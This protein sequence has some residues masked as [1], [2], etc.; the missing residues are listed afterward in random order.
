M[1]DLIY[2]V[3][4]GQTNKLMRDMGDGTHAD[5][6]AVGPGESHIG[7]IGGN[8]ALFSADFGP[9]AAKTY[10]SGQV[11]GSLLEVTGAARAAGR[12]GLMTSA[13]LVL[14]AANAAQ[15]DVL[16]FNTQPSGSFADGAALALSLADA[17][18]LSHV[19]HVTDWTALAAAISQGQAPAEP[20]VYKCLDSVKTTSLFALLVARG[21]LSLAA[22]TDGNLS[23]RFARN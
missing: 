5:V 11:I 2:S 17:K 14:N 1:S 7:E 13:S 23:L 9:G 19:C 18:K 4:D 20:R 3:F 8:E 16:I 15:I 22:P 6:Q 12:G 10:A 21:A